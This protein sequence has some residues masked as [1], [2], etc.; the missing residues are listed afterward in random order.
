MLGSTFLGLEHEGELAQCRSCGHPVRSRTAICPHCGIEHP[1]RRRPAFRVAFPA[2]AAVLGA[3][4]LALIARNLA[5]DPTAP[6]AG[7]VTSA[8]LTPQLVVARPIQAVP[9]ALPTRGP[10]KAAHPGPLAGSRVVSVADSQA[11]TDS[12]G[13]GASLH[14]RWIADW[15]NMRRAPANEAAVVRVL[16]PGTEVRATPSKWGWWAIVWQGDTVGYVAGALLR[17]NRPASSR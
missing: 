17:A 16:A 12:A 4:V 14:T 2:A 10:A 9:P 15:S 1:A 11:L 6:R 5:F 3:L 8:G 13:Q 7:Q